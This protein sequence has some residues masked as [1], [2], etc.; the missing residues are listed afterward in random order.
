M[1]VS[2]TPQLGTWDDLATRLDSTAT[3]AQWQLAEPALAGF[4]SIAEI[5]DA[6]RTDEVLGALVRLAAADGGGCA[7]AVLVVMQLLR[8]GAVR[9]A[10]RLRS[11]DPEI[12]WLIAGQLAVQIRSFPVSRRTRAFAANILLDT[13]AALLKELRPYAASSKRRVGVVTVDPAELVDVINEI[14]A[15]GTDT[16]DSTTEVVDLLVWAERTGVLD[17]DDIAVLMNV[18]ACDI[19][20]GVTGRAHAA[21]VLGLSLST[22]ARRHNR[23]VAA[24]VAARDAYLAA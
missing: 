4:G 13:Q 15:A 10:A 24:L 18:T 12:N 19:P 2:F 22:V 23:A 21:A 3:L 14:A 1:T 20:A 17:P 9:L 16:D 5:G 11:L 7:D 6:D 8:P